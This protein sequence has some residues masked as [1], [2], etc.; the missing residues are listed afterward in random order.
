MF[1]DEKRIGRRG[2]LAAMGIATG[3]VL[4]P[5]T[6]C[7]NSAGARRE[8]PDVVA[9]LKNAAHPLRSTEPGADTADLRPLETMIGD[10]KV[11]GLGEAT[12]GSHEFFAM[13]ERVFRHLVE[14]KGFTT[15]ALEVSWSAGL[16]I[17]DYLQTGEGDARTIAKR[18]LTGTPWHREEFVSLIAW[19]RDH[20]RSHPGRPLRFIGDDIGAPALSD[21]FFSRITGYVQRTHPRSLARLDELYTGLRPIDDVFAYLGRPRSERQLLAA[22]AL[23]ALELVSS[24]RGADPTE[25][26]LAVQNAR[27]VSQTATFLAFE[28]ADL[29]NEAE[30]SAAHLYRDQVM[31]D[32]TAWWQRH[33]GGKILLSG[34]NGHVGYTGGNPDIYLKTQGAFLRD[35]MGGD[36]LPIGFTFHQGSF[37][38]NDEPLDG[39]WKTFT[40]GPAEPGTNEHTLH[41]VRRQDYYLDLRTV[42]AAARTWLNT[43]RP[44]RDIGTQ[45]PVPLENIALGRAYDVLVHLQEI[46][47]AGRARP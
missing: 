36:Y 24:I 37:L 26:Q 22:N 5:V 6:A 20:N 13:K 42:P 25:F 1:R 29:T 44:T 38:S 14:T 27:S 43:A 41:R 2:L 46:R 47:E 9:L 31:A 8:E 17:D 40:A 32:N 7:T 21:D 3:A 34:H 39:A 30:L 10:A 18:A 16:L 35:L 45:Y 28:F 11:V 15:F 23:Q 12:H 4:V 33:T 19:M